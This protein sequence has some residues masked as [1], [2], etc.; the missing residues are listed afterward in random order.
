MTVVSQRVADVVATRILAGE[1]APGQ[2][3]KQDELATELS[4]SRIPVREALRIL[5][6]RG[7]VTIRANAGAWVTSMSRHDLDLSYEIRERIEPLLLLDSLPFLTDEHLGEMRRLQ[8]Q[9]Q[10]NQDVEAFLR[11]DREFHW[12]SYA[13]ARSKPLATMVNRLWDSTQAYRRAFV[14]LSQSQ[15]SWVIS[16]EHEL[17][18]DALARREGDVAAHVLGLHIRRTR[19]ALRE[20]PEIVPSV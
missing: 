6:L 7:L 8:D 4:A 16:A 10:D 1:L 13:G 2:R 20:H 19:V 17:L 15:G 18:L 3:I 11:L 5:E 12:T 9:I 14:R